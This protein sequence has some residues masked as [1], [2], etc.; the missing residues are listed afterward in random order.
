[1]NTVLVVDDRYRFVRLHVDNLHGSNLQVVTATSLDELTAMYERHRDELAGIILDGCV[2]GDK[3]N[4]LPFIQAV[5]SDRQEGLFNGLLI[6]ASSDPSYRQAMVQH[7][8]THEAPKSEA[9][10]LLRR[11]LGK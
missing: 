3:L 2:P 8:C 5:Y 11:L 7:G 6:A 1:M 4:T 9:A 10:E